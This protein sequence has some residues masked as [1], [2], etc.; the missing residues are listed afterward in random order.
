MPQIHLLSFLGL[1][2][3]FSLLTGRGAGLARIPV[4]IAYIITGAILGPAILG[5]VNLAQVETLGFINV[6]TLSLIGFNIG[7]ELRLK[8]LR[9]LGR[10][11]IIIVIFEAS[12]AFLVTAI[13]TA[14]ITRSIPMGI[15]YGALACAT[16][17][18]GTIDVIN[19]YKAKGELTSTLFAVMGLDDIYALILY[20]LGIPLAGIMLG[21]HD[22]S[23]SLAILDAFKDIGLEIIFGAALATC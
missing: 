23:V 13:A 5:Y 16:A 22:V 18:A 4:I 20:S 2:L 8:D 17:P 7:S 10:K 21:S 3:L 11:I 15:I 14:L 1:C 19:Q 9:K 12:V 6:L